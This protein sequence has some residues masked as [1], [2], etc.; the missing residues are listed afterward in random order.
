MR[1]LKIAR[2]ISQ[3][4]G[5][6]ITAVFTCLGCFAQPSAQELAL[7]DQFTA[8]SRQALQEKLYLHTDKDFYVAG[9]ICWFKIYNT[10]AGFN[11][12]L[13]ISKLAYIEVF[14]KNN[15][16]VL[17][18][19]V[20]LNGGSGNGS[21]QWPISLS[22][23]K[24]LLRAYTNWMKNFDAAYFFEKPL[25]IINTR[26]IYTDT[27]IA[28]KDSYNAR[29]YPEGG[30]L[31]NGLQSTVAFRITDQDG[32]GVS[33]TGAVVDEKSDTL[34]SFATAKF[35]MGKFLFTPGQS[36]TYKA[37]I[38][39]SGNRVEQALPAVY[40]GGYVMHLSKENNGQLKITV[41]SSAVN[42]S[43][44]VV[45]LFA[46]TRGIVKLTNA[47]EMRAGECV[48]L[49]DTAKLGD[50]ISQFTIFNAAQQPV[51]ERLFFKKPSQVL[52]IAA[53]SDK[54]VYE[55]RSK[56]T[57]HIT[58]ANATGKPLTANMSMAV[59]R[60]DTLT[61]AGE[62]DIS[63][64]LWLRSDLAG[65]IESP[66]YYFSAPAEPAAE[67]A[68]NLML[69]Q[70]WRRFRWED[71]LQNRKPSFQFVPEYK[72]HI[73]K[74]RVT[75][76][77]GVP[78]KGIESFLTVP[79]TKTQFR[80]AFSDDSGTVKFEMSNFYGND[81]I[82]VQTTGQEDGLRHVDIASPFAEKL[83][84]SVLPPFSLPTMQAVSLAGLHLDVQVQN[85][86]LFNKLKQAALPPA[87]DTTAFYSKPDKAY[88]LDDY[89]RFTTVEEILREYVP[90]VNVRK[91]NGKFQL[92]VFD[93]IRKEFFRVSPLILLDG[94][95]VL[96]AD[97]IMSYDPLKIKK[98][99]V[100]A[101]MYFY[102]NMFFG[103]IINFITYQGDIPGF[104][105]DPHATVIDYGTL[106]MQREFFSPSYETPQ[107]AAGRLP[108]FRTLLYWSPNVQTGISGRNETAFYT[109]DLPGRYAAVIEGITSDGK[110]G[111]KTVFF[112]VKEKDA[113]AGSR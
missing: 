83:P 79:G 19:K 42:E 3:S 2:L 62:M 12:P 90:D 81:E 60:V 39:I 105:L 77:A 100:L 18:A 75:T 43:S 48:F 74:G 66:G 40:P 37:I 28:K 26:K 98:L 4:T 113:L 112:T 21:L 34:V 93:N 56:L 73:V 78:A 9:E 82:I 44:R 103:G 36:H 6:C 96:D 31:V 110:T 50:G 89:V 15:K 106:Q 23:G 88:W 86:Y 35:G 5:V 107:L 45:Y 92:P 72:G 71:V 47:A 67:A 27:S 8:Y 1:Q 17:Q 91:R 32:R 49:V 64:Y 38:S 11:L 14:D 10:D 99:E 69:T 59:L 109:S 80:D 29:F 108:D 25:T 87:V 22:S 46:H 95:P 53:S 76:A 33:C 111:S 55:P 13:G 101:R 52:E 51:C 30:N 7:K 70:G 41:R 94:V 68:D 63:S 65:H 102:G 24:Y 85:A 84:V 54:E 16:P 57:M 104:E 61:S 97:K 20:A 58:A